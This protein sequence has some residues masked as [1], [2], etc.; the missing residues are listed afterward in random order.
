MSHQSAVPV[1]YPQPGERQNPDNDQIPDTFACAEGY[2]CTDG[3][4]N[5]EDLF[6]KNI[7]SD[8]DHHQDFIPIGPLRISVD[9]VQFYIS[10]LEN[11]LLAYSEEDPA[12]QHIP[13]VTI[14]LTVSPNSAIPGGANVEDFQ[15]TL[16][17]T[18]T[19]ELLSPVPAPI[20]G[21]YP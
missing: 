4:P 12:I 9:S 17:E 10:P 13:Y 5:A 8:P 18:V 3:I 19:T 1:P 16:Q 6:Y 20:R 14:F 11:P 15:I 21:Q 2:S 7:E